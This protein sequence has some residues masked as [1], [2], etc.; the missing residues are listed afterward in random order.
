MVARIRVIGTLFISGETVTLFIT[1]ENS[2][3]VSCKTDHALI[4][5][6]NR[7][8]YYVPR[9]VENLCIH[10]HTHTHIHTHTHTMVHKCL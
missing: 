7:I 9:G 10:T 1:Y 8:Y 4:Q 2:L 5:F 6:N 3:A